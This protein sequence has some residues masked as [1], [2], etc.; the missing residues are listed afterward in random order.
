[1]WGLR[2][3]SHSRLKNYQWVSRGF[4]FQLSQINWYCTRPS[5]VNRKLW[6]WINGTKQLCSDIGQHWPIGSARWHPQAKQSQVV[7]GSPQLCEQTFSDW[8]SNL[9]S[10]RR[11]TEVKMKDVAGVCGAALEVSAWAPHEPSAEGSLDMHGG[12]NPRLS[13]KWLLWDWEWSRNTVNEYCGENQVLAKTELEG[14]PVKHLGC[15]L[16]V[17]TTLSK[18]A[19]FRSSLLLLLLSRFSRIR[20]RVTP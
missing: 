6:N 9:E 10:K 14:H 11:W 4:L 8:L 20:L 15:V 17:R 3:N 16:E 12:Q 2:N 19:H 7:S 18:K 5:R 1:M 13:R